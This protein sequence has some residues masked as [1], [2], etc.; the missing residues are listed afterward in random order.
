MRDAAHDQAGFTLMEV[1]AALAVFSIA[2]LA[3]L[4]LAAEN[5]RAAGAAREH[6]FASLVA[7]NLMVEAVA[8]PQTV[9]LGV[10]HGAESMDRR[11]WDWTR[12][13]QASGEPGLWRIDVEVRAAGERR[14]SAALT[15]FRSGE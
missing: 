2:A 14:V 9:T 6:T 4:H 8:L 5:V 15:G 10:S 11:D 12:T 7:E 3:L 1:M 13:V